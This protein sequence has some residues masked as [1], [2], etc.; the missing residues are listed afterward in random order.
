MNAFYFCK[1]SPLGNFKHFNTY[2]FIFFLCIIS[3]QQKLFVGLHSWTKKYLGISSTQEVERKSLPCGY[4]ESS[5]VWLQSRSSDLL[6]SQA[7]VIWNGQQREVDSDQKEWKH[8]WHFTIK[9]RQLWSNFLKDAAS[10]LD[11]QA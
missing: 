6:L 5:S 10:S 7:D 8:S 4:L 11:C 9:L 1:P 3:C 2:L